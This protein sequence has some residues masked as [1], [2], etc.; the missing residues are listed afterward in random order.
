MVS[1]MLCLDMD[2]GSIF[3]DCETIACKGMSDVL[4][5]ISVFDV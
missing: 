3:I 1:Y 5:A 4:R 2:S